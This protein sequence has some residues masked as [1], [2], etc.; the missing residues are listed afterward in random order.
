M[1]R[2]KRVSELN[3]TDHDK[4]VCASAEFHDSISSL[5]IRLRPVVPQ[6]HALL[7]LNRHI[8]QTVR[9]VTGDDPPWTKR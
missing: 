9:E 4:L 1:T 7:D 5:M 3:I 2:H 6:Y 8:N